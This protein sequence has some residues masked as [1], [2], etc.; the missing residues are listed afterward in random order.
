MSTF[1]DGWHFSGSVSSQYKQIG[2]AVPV[3]LA[4]AVGR[5]IVALL[6]SI[7]AKVEL[8]SDSLV[9]SELFYPRQLTL[10]NT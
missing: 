3:N 9:A 2:N 1:P 10:L 5:S 8:G 6:N 4:Y 7:D